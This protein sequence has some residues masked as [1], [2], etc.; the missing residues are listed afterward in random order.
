MKIAFVIAAAASQSAA[1]EIPIGNVAIKVRTPAV[2][3]ATSA[4]LIFHE[5]ETE[6]GTYR[7]LFDDGGT[8]EDV[9]V[10]VNSAQ[11]IRMETNQTLKGCRFLKVTTTTDDSAT[12]VAQ[13]A[14]REFE[15]ICRQV[16]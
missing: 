10:V 3:T 7:P 8:V 4:R 9:T 6:D 16:H 11:T 2:L 5:S 1:I 12:A 15:F 13:A 14:E